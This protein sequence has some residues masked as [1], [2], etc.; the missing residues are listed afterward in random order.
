[1]IAALLLGLSY[2]FAA[3]VSPGPTLGLVLAQTLQRGWR[4]GVLVALA[5]LCSDLPIVL[6]S[7]TVLDQFSVAAVG[8][9]SC[10]GGLFVV[11]LGYAR[12]VARSYHSSPTVKL[13]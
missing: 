9:L 5:P 2:G 8:W 3:S 4:A 12:G 1:V 7:V 10:I 13:I 6:L 11:Y